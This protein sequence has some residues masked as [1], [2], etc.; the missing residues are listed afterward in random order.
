MSITLRNAIDA[1]VQAKALGNRRERYVDGLRGYLNQFARGREDRPLDQFGVDAIE[2]WFAS[3]Q[4]ALT[5]RASNIGRLSALFSFG[6]RRKWIPENP[7]RQ[8]ERITIERPVPRILT[9]EESERLMRWGQFQRPEALGYLVKALYV[10]I[11]PEEADRLHPDRIDESAGLIIIDAAASKVR[12]RRIIELQPA[13][14]EWL[15]EARRLKCLEPV[16]LSTRRRWIK[17]ARAHLEFTSWPQDVLRHSAASYLLAK[18]KNANLVAEWMGNSAD[19][20]KTHYRELVSAEDTAAFWA[21]R[22]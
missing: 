14:V 1:C 17:E 20:L 21:I 11:R 9:P 6:V 15:A 16:H 22:P 13:A 4:E 12:N 18:V 5:T 7:C 3:R 2:H 10:G 8:L 19:I